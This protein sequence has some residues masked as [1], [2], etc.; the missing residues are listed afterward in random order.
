MDVAGRLVA[1]AGRNGEALPAVALDRNAKARQQVER[2]LDVGLGDQLA[3]HLDHDVAG[4]CA[5]GQR[6]RH[7]QR[8]QEL[9]G[10]VAA[11]G[12][13]RVQPQGRG[14]PLMRSGG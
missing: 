13:G 8:G 10:H 5:H 14:C 9:A 2:D 7:Q 1:A 3:D 11:H 6:Q 4:R 12:D